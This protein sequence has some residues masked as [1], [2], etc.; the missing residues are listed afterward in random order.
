[1]STIRLTTRSKVILAILI[2]AGLLALISTVTPD[3][4]KVSPDDMSQAC[5]SL[6]Y[7]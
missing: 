2:I 7:S 6:I 3:E 5:K 1:M 4:C